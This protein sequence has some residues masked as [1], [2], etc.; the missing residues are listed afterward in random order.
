MNIR[1]ERS[2]SM[3]IQLIDGQEKY[4]S[5]KEKIKEALRQADHIGLD[6]YDGSELIGFAMLRK[7]DRTVGFCGIS[8][9][10]ARF[11][12]EDTDANP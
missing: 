9:S 4:L 11:R 1:F 2:D 8:L 12:T 5:S 6:I 10:T 3:K 7:Y